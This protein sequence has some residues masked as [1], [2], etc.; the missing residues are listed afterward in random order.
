MS[1]CAF[2]VL[3]AACGR[4]HFDPSS[5]GA[6]DGPPAGGD[7]AILGDGSGSLSIPC[8]DLNI[9][10]ATGA[11]VASGSVLGQ[12]NDD[13]GCNGAGAD[14]AIGWFAPAAGRYRFDLC[15]SVDVSWDSSLSIRSGSCTGAELA[16]ADLGC[17]S[18]HAAVELDV[19]AGQALVI[20]VN[21]TTP[22]LGSSFR[23][24]ITPQ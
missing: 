11:N 4:L 16:C 24:G 9:G 17:L 2:V 3:V 10:S 14:V 21:S 12:G 19:V 20:V 7:G 8:A 18:T 15:G 23:L 6:D 5:T 22:I 1:G 13:P